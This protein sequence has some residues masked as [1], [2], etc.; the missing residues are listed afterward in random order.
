MANEEQIEQLRL[1]LQALDTEEEPGRGDHLFALITKTI[2]RKSIVQCAVQSGVA[3]KLGEKS[4]TN[5]AQIWAMVH[6]EPLGKIAVYTVSLLE[7]PNN[8]ENV[9][10]QFYEEI[11]HKPDHHYGAMS[12]DAV[13]R[14]LTEF[15]T[16]DD[17]DEQ[18]PPAQLNGH[19]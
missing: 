17:D 5:G 11:L 2:K 1:L 9:G 15:L 13:Y 19:A 16:A 4:P 14:Q 10:V 18:Q 7:D 8:K 6:W 12:A 3:Y